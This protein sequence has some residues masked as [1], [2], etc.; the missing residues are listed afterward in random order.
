MEPP[1]SGN[2]W[3]SGEVKAFFFLPCPKEGVRDRI[4]GGEQLSLSKI[5]DS[6]LAPLTENIPWEPSP[7]PWEAG[8]RAWESNE[9]PAGPAN[10]PSMEMLCSHPGFPRCSEYQD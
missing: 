7:D 2:S 3:K 5:C 4:F 8:I 10:H 9:E 1:S 6:P